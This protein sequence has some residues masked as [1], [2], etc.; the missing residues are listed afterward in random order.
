MIC[1]GDHRS[2]HIPAVNNLSHP[3]L[4]TLRHHYALSKMN[5]HLTPISATLFLAL[6]TAA[7]AAD[8]T[9]WAARGVTTNA[10]QSNLSP[11][12]IGQAKH[13]V[14]MALA[15]LQPRLAAPTFQA[16][17]ADVATIVSLAVP[18]TPDDFAK[19]KQVLL[20]G[21]LKALAR[22]FYDR[23]RA[24]DAPW[25]NQNMSLASIRLL[26]PGSNPLSYSPY[27]W[28]VT[29]TDDSNYSP[30]TLGQLKAVFSL[31]YEDW[32]ILEPADPPLPS[33]PNDTDSDG[34]S[35]VTEAAIGTSPTLSDS[36]GDTYIDSVDVYPLDPTRWLAL[37]SVSGDLTPP[38][39]VLDSPATAT[40]VAGP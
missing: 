34:L 16:L 35:D 30:A 2:P 10:P 21:Q 15:E 4:A 13:M 5:F 37:A 6:S 28:S 32:G 8:P 24:L 11:A 9:W 38:L 29:T 18:A 26:E 25:V 20:V 33:G 31:H 7:P 22:P 3:S 12:T 39:I 17:Q 1:G 19:Q 14:A 36:D 27:P 23:L 40:Y